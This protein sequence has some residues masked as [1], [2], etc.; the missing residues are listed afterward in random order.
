MKHTRRT[1]FIPRRKRNEC[2]ECNGGNDAN[3]ISEQGS[4]PSQDASSGPPANE[5]SD[6][7]L[8][9]QGVYYL[10]GDVCPD[11]VSPIVK[12]LLIKHIASWQDP[13]FI[14]IHTSGGSATDM[15]SLI[16]LMDLL[17]FKV[18]T[19]GVGEC[20]SAGSVLLCS[21]SPGCRYALKNTSIMT[22]QVRCILNTQASYDG[23]KSWME[24]FE[25]EHLRILQHFCKRTKCRTKQAVQDHL[26]RS[27]DTFLTSE[28]AKELGVIDRVLTPAE[29]KKLP[30]R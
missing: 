21:G 14:L 6:K 24:D 29:F 26:L 5:T 9:S 7:L 18:Y 11:T 27:Q 16:D 2:N 13:V 15:W 8:G 30:L 12:D 4:D 20:S 23:I 25:Q 17:P 19:I 28:R 22:H 10:D 3:P 1:S